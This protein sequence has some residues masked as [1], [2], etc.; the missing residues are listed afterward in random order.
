MKARLPARQVRIVVGGV[1]QVNLLPPEVQQARAMRQA[2]RVVVGAIIA[3]VVVAASGVGGAYLYSEGTARN[4]AS[5]QADSQRL[6]STQATFAQVTSVRQKLVQAAAAHRSITAHVVD[7]EPYFDALSA[8]LPSTLQIRSMA[9]DS[10]TA[11]AQTGAVQVAAAGPPHVATV[12]VH[13]LTPRLSPVQT[14]LAALPA[15]KG[16][17]DASPGSVT[18]DPNGELDVAVVLHLDGRSYAAATEGPASSVTPLTPGHS[19][20]AAATTGGQ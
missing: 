11:S 13:V 9:V 18:S 4:L 14:W 2:R 6:L 20:A 15:L 12:T 1:P 16:Y 5:A 19:A 8:S 3:T 17:V 10:T 7:W